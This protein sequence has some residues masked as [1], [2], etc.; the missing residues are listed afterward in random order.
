MTD[1][2]A[3][4]APSRRAVWLGRSLR[5]VTG[6]G[7]LALV[8]AV[9]AAGVRLPAHD[10]AA[11]DDGTH[12]DVPPSA[13]T[14]TCPAPLI[15]PAS[16]GDR[17]FDP[18]PVAPAMSVV[19]AAAASAGTTVAPAA[20]GA[21]AA[22]LAPG[23]AVARISD[24][25]GSLVVRAEP[26]DTAAQVGAVA[27]SVV[28]A[29]D[30][31]G[32]SAASC[33]RPTT[34]AWLVGGGTDLSSTAQLVISA[35][36]ST[37]AEVTI[38]VYGP[39]G[40]VDLTADH[41]LVAPGHQRVVVLGAVAPEQR[42]IAVRVR[43]TGGA[44]TAYVQDSSLDGFTP[45]G[46]DLVVPGAPP[47]KRQVVPG[48]SVVEAGVDSP[49]AGSLRLV[50]PGARGTTAHVRILGPD[51]VVALPG[52]QRVDLAPGE[53]TDV[54][55]GGLPAGAYT[56]VVDADRPVLAAGLVARAGAATAV[57]P[58]PSLERA[59]VPSSPAGLGGI[60]TIPAGTRGTLV[61]TAVGTT[62]DATGTLRVIGADGRVVGER[63]VRI[64][65]GTTGSWVA[66]TLVGDG[67][68]VPGAA[69]QAAAAGSVA[70]LQLVPDDG[71][72]RLAWALVAEVARPDGMFVSVLAPVP[73]QDDERA[74]T[75]R[76]DPRVG[77]R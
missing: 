16:G 53:V 65:A 63:K 74:V 59:W 44:V 10:P 42:R 14:L 49:L 41:Y 47:A 22:T 52:A 57:D 77:T 33:Q 51:G 37:P 32:L 11:A 20:G 34:D 21:P 70:A 60:A 40:K 36:G 2:I 55:L 46:T 15:L 7:V 68:L 23:S 62:G 12:V 45:Q 30:L 38:S 66:E 48:L 69:G 35:A 27:G 19:A 73:A 39:S 18:V 26:G 24:P 75:V 58:A 4:Q 9:V 28:T 25:A 61:A 6:I 76:Y 71:D 31:R 43:A 13:V 72:V 3:T 56:A 29:G 17:A 54:P 8:G 67:Q 50:V 64:P 5:A 1:D